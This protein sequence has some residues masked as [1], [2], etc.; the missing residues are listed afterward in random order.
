MKDEPSPGESHVSHPFLPSVYLHVC[1][2]NTPGALRG[3]DPH[4][5]KTSFVCLLSHVISRRAFFLLE[6]TKRSAL[7]RQAGVYVIHK[8]NLTIIYCG[9]GNGYGTR[10]RSRSGQQ[11]L[12][13]RPVLS[14]SCPFLRMRKEVIQSYLTVTPFRRWCRSFFLLCNSA[15]KDMATNIEK[16]W[17]KM[18]AA[19][20]SGSAQAP[21]NKGPE[22]KSRQFA[23][24]TPSPP[25]SAQ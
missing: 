12:Q 18:I 3:W 23:V 4:V 20:D 13:I 24:R 2:E 16:S 7:P 25:H 22:G 8:Q 17:R 10:A 14:T 5:T 11:P 15:I 21:E 1:P 6:S 9:Y 19:M